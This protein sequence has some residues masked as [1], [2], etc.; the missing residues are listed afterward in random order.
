MRKDRKIANK[1][2]Q[3]GAPGLLVLN[4]G[5]NGVMPFTANG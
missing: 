2:C 5:L 3:T 1:M 4:E